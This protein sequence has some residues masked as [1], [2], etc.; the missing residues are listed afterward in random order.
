MLFKIVASFLAITVPSFATA[1]EDIAVLHTN[2]VYGLTVGTGG[3]FSI[4]V[5]VAI[6]GAPESEGDVGVADFNIA[7]RVSGWEEEVRATCENEEF[8]LENS[9]LLFDAFQED[10][11][12]C[13]RRFVAALNA[14]F[15]ANIVSSPI[16]LRMGK[17]P[18]GE[19]KITF[20]FSESMQVDLPRI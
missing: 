3:P 8:L 1:P 12:N 17:Q 5:R 15:K 19:S 10:P 9:A 16:T 14:Q 4:D 6:K 7:V 18:N 20:V 11:E 13:T 2:P